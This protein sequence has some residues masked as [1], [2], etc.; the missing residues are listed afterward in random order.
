MGGQ[1]LVSRVTSVFRDC[2][3]KSTDTRVRG[4]FFDMYGNHDLIQEKEEVLCVGLSDITIPTPDFPKTVKISGCFW[5]FD[6]GNIPWYA[7]DKSS[8]A[9]RAELRRGDRG[10][11]DKYLA[12]LWESTENPEKYKVYYYK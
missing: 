5:L 4:A 2:L 10:H 3:A 6:N 8:V 12:M 1:T 11:K 7:R 9:F